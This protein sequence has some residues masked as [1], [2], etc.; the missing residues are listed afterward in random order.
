MWVE[1]RRSGDLFHGFS[2]GLHYPRSVIFDAD[3]APGS[4]V[5]TL[6]LADQK[7]AASKGTAARS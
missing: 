4:H 2:S 6:K 7:N 1:R 3:L 5:L